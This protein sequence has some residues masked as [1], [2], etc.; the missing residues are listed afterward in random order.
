MKNGHNS[1][2]PVV[3]TCGGWFSPQVWKNIFCGANYCKTDF[4]SMDSNKLVTGA[5]VAAGA[6]ALGAL[7]FSIFADDD[8]KVMDNENFTQL[9]TFSPAF[10][11]PASLSPV[12]T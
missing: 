5:L 1:S 11:L 3:S 6:V 10:F 9:L 12:T 2:T 4:T 7:M 8:E